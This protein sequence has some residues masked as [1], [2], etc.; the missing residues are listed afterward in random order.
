MVPNCGTCAHV[1]NW[2]AETDTLHLVET[3]WVYNRD[4]KITKSAAAFGVYDGPILVV[5]HNGE[6][7]QRLMGARAITPGVVLANSKL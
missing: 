5:V 2:L 4:G 7:V 6:V 1:K 3:E